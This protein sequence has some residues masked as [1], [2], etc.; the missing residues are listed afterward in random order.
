MMTPET[1]CQEKG[2]DLVYFD[3]RGTNTPGMFNKKHN[4]IAIDTYLDGIYKHKVIYHELGHREHTA[5]YYKLNK[6]KA[7]LQADR[8]MIHH[9]LKEE[10]SHWD[11][12]EDFNY[13]QFMEKY[14]LTSIADEVMV[15]EELEFLI[16]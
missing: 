11:N 15:K 5:S 13:I 10:L 1:V 12:M 2:I 9:L 8:C 16:S 3:G 4:V 6:E 7:E 14:E